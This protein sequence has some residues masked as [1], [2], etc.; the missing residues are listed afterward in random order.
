MIPV[1]ISR[2]GVDG[3]FDRF[4]HE[5]VLNPDE[6][7]TIMFGPNGIG[8]TMILALLDTLFNRSVWN[9]GRMPFQEVNVFFDNN[10]VLKVNRRSEQ[11]IHING[12][13]DSKLRLEYSRTT[14]QPETFEPQ[15]P[16]SR[17]SV[18]FPIDAIED[19]I[20]SLVQFGPAAWRDLNTGEILDLDEVVGEYGEQLPLQ[21]SPDPPWL[22]EIKESMQVRF[23]GI[24]RLTQ[25]SSY[26]IRS[27]SSRR[28]NYSSRPFPERTVRRYSNDL[29]QMIQKKV[30]EY[31]SL[32]QS[33]DRTFPARLVQDTMSPSLTIRELTEKLEEVE[34]KRSKFLNAGLLVQEAD[35][36]VAAIK[37]VNTVDSTRQ[38]VLA[39]YAE[40]AVKKLSVFDDLYA[41]VN[42]LMRIVNKRFLY[43]QVS[44]SAQ[45]LHVLD[46][47][48]ADLALEMLSSGE[49]HEL[50]L[51]YGLLFGISENSLVMIDEPELSLHVA[52]QDMLLSDLQ[53][54]AQLSDFHVLLATHSPQIIRDRWDLTVELEGTH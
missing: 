20:P 45:G 47:D 16:R 24:E 3:L 23:I 33:L 42:A 51:L 35:L 37:S 13:E 6:K 39:V 21:D 11:R 4:D 34:D 31:A 1:K 5:L 52:W 30:T 14:G 50:V 49:Q 44:V 10:T 48:G 43:K 54:M 17:E 28:R 22:A 8:K 53:E 9:L 15:L 46:E 29:A 32:S 27:T 7:I 25:Q 38:E 26:E 40:D 19:W 41:R 2:I 12:Y 36:D 18:H